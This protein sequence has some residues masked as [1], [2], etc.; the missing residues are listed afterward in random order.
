MIDL[1]M[2]T[3][4]SDG[5]LLPSEL[6]Q[7]CAAAGYSALAITD[8]ADS[9]NLELLI[10]SACRV[11]EDFERMK[12]FPVRVLP[13]V[14]LTHVIPT[15]IAKLTEQARSLGARI[16]VVHG[17]TISE[18]VPKGTNRAAI[19]AGVDILAH[20]GLITRE[21]VE[22]AA[23][24]GV[25]LELTTRRAHAMTNGHVARLARDASA[26]MVV[27]SDTHT[28]ADILTT[29]LRERTILGAGLD[30][31]FVKKLVDTATTLVNTLSGKR[32]REGGRT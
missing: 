14:E 20:P 22:L 7:R 32:M 17:E 11:A 25:V 27:N 1:H 26:A 5:E 4:L 12:D 16:V 9:S 23:G 8:H 13:G 3:F 31:S 30:A 6:V 2:H 24:R 28:P 18:P 10:T 29:L 19:E 21:D 15:M